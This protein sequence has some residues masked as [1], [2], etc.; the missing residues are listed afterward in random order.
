[1]ASNVVTLFIRADASVSIGTGHVMRMIAL[2]QSWQERGGEVWFICGEIPSAL[3]QRLTNE[4]FGLHRIQAALG[5]ENDLKQTVQFIFE[6]LESNL[7]SVRVALDGYHFGADYQLGIMKA[8]FKSLVVDDYGHATF[9]H[10]DWVLNQN[11]SAREELYAKR[12]PSAE[13][14]LGP[15]YAMLRQEFL[16]Y[17]GWKREIA[18]VGKKVLVTLGGS[19]PD[20]VTL[21]VLKSLTG[22]QLHAKVV[23]GGGNP[24]LSG[25]EEFIQSNVG[26]ATVIESVVNAMNMP[27]LMAWADIAVAAAG[28]TCWELAF[29]GLPS[30]ALILAENQRAIGYELQKHGISIVIDSK[31]QALTSE[32]AL[33]MPDLQCDLALR[34]GVAGKG[35]ALIDGLGVSRLVTLLYAG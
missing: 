34:S 22:L 1:M 26:G 16:T 14:L 25:I 31:T 29:M 2:G 15:E 18:P 11:I 5:S 27:E 8:G 7:S 13:L 9:Y 10:A 24:H 20:N 17:R 30:F 19:D 35:Q 33:K 12:S 6:T 28:S 21:K 32:V 23:I 3:E 4:R